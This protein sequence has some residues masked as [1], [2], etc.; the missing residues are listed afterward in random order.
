MPLSQ[1]ARV[2]PYR[3]EAGIG[4]GG[5]G[6][7]FRAIDTR[8]DRA[9][10][11]KIL[12][13]HRWS[14]PELR[15]RIEREARALSAL[16]HPNL[17]ALY[18]VGELSQ[19]GTTTPYLVMELLEG[20]TLRDRLNS[21]GVSV[22]RALQWAAQLASGL[23]AAHEKGVIH[24]DLK[25]ENVIV[26]A[27]DL[28]K[29]LD[30]GL[31]RGTEPESDAPTVLRTQTGFVMGTAEYMSPEQARGTIVGPQSDI[32]SLGI[33]LYEMLTGETPFHRASAVETMNAILIADPPPVSSLAPAVS[34]AVDALVA[35]CLEKDPA[36]RFSSARDL[37]YALESTARAVTTTTPKAVRRQSS[38]QRAPV[39][40]RALLLAGA[41]AFLSVAGAGLISRAGVFTGAHEPI[42]A[43]VRPLTY[44]GRDSSPAASPDGR[45]VAFVSTRDT[46]KQIWLKSLSDGTEVAITSGPDDAAPR[47]AADGGRVFFTRTE[48]GASAIH[49]VAVLGGE[50]RK[51][52]TNGFDADPAPDGRSIAFI[53]N[54]GAERLSTIVIATVDGANERELAASAEDEFS[55]P[56]WSRDGEWLAVTR[57]PRATAPGSVL[58]INTRSGAT[59]ELV[60]QIPHSLVS[61]VAWLH[62][63]HALLYLEV[64][65]AGTRGLPRRRGGSSLV[66]QELDGNA[67]I[68]M[69]HQHGAIDTVDLLPDG[70]IV[71]TQ[72]M[73]RQNLQEV[74]LDRDARHWISRGMSVDRQPA[75]ARNGESIVFTSDRGDNV[76]LW[77]V[78]LATRALRR[79]TDSPAVDWDPF[80]ARDA[81]T[82]YWSSDRGG[83]FEIWR[84]SPDGAS[85]QQVTQDG[86]DAENPSLAADSDWIYYDGTNARQDGLWRRRLV[87]GRA[88]LVVPG[89]TI[90][91]EVSPD[92]AYVVFQRPET[93]GGATLEVV[94]TSDAARFQFVSG[95]SG[96]LTL[97]PRW[98]GTG[99]RI[100]Y[101]GITEDGHI[102]VYIQDLRFGEDTSATRRLLVDAGSDASIETF[103][104]SPDA[105][106][107]VI[108]VIDDASAIVIVDGARID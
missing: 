44:S 6:H 85:P 5:M 3:I 40:R 34:E 64:E 21:G 41:V 55:S 48:N 57:N 96:V 19:N 33:V 39:S 14:D 7:V 95:T 106:R 30:F 22:R 20:E 18:D 31:A 12:P 29:I 70:R 86:T 52:I 66:L 92:G 36:Q 76:D 103:A 108:A 32:F 11:I 71:M 72:D 74:A 15:H 61:S 105:S 107:A 38:R 91:P 8:L 24:R 28:L 94:R 77:E 73:T 63:R 4:A 84:A 10:A 45:L 68:V 50:P 46:Q 80:P 27:G 37:A 82:L 62:D 78:T 16:N 17:C 35:R 60:H 9:V 43:R 65:A 79:L 51:I 56:R 83:H 49:Y 26:T 54:R 59:R 88:E 42:P 58:L 89:E 69:R 98:A 75:Y 99:S 13:P 67:R 102:A 93:G 1:G 25:P 81:S 2:G 90:H 101:R 47:F 87:D 104:I 100:A 97:R 23:A 53:R